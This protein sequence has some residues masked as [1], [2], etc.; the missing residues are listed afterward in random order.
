M[1]NLK[2]KKIL[3]L[4]G[5]AAT[6]NVVQLAHKM[7]IETHVTGIQEGGQAKEIADYTLLAGSEEHDKLMQYIQDNNIDGVMTGSAEFQVEEMIKLCAKT[8]LHC[9]ATELQW[10]KEHCLK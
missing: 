8:G 10:E 4:G 7:G 5:K 1:K 6:V 2:G 9:Y 3:I